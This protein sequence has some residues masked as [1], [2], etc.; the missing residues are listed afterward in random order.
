MSIFIIL[1]NK[2]IKYKIRKE[3]P[4]LEK[5]NKFIMSLTKKP[6]LAIDIDEVLAQFIPTLAVFHN[7]VHGTNYTAESF[8]SYEFHR[9]WGGSVLECNAKVDAFFESKYFKE[10]IIPVP[11]AKESLLILKE[12]FELHIVTARQHK[13][14]T[15]TREWIQKYFPNIFTTFNFGNHYSTEGKSRSKSQMCNEIG[16][17]MLVDDSALYA[18]QC[19]LNGIP[20]ILFGD[21]AWNRDF[22]IED[23]SE[24]SKLVTRAFDWDIAMKLIYERFS[25]ETANKTNENEEEDNGFIIAAIQMCSTDIKSNNLKSIERLVGRAVHEKGA[26]IC[27]LPECCVFIGS[28]SADTIANAE[29]LS[30]P[31]MKALCLIA[32]NY[33]VWLSV[34][35]ISESRLDLGLPERVSNVHVIINPEGQIENP[36]YRKIHLFDS[37]FSGL[38]ESKITGI[39]LLYHNI[40]CF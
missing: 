25:I 32:K 30:G 16:A 2:Q 17:I 23:N 6:I 24:L 9:I 12:D 26:Q 28:N 27:C 3:V 19:S 5:G 40:V 31:S 22:T 8:V 35:G 4:F 1:Q 11:G 18:Q 34:G 13:Y 37:H 14:E 29:S 38:H 36:I 7:E 20:V 33:S 39:H 15:Q 21:Y 10:D